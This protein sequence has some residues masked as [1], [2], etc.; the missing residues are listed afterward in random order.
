MIATIP[1]PYHL[2]S[3]M[4]VITPPTETV[5]ND[6]SPSLSY[7]A[8]NAISVMAHLKPVSSRDSMQYG[9]ESTSE[10]YE[11]YC[12]P[13]AALVALTVAQVA[14]SQIVV[15]GKTLRAASGATN[16]SSNGCLY[17]ITCERVQ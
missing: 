15:D 11:L 3:L 5:A 9:R 12:E 13:K 4:A 17:N 8:G 14:K 2:L 7:D 16:Q 1:T 10:M 6:G